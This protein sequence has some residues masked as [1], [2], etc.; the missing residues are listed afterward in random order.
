MNKVTIAWVILLTFQIAQAAVEPYVG[1]KPA[2]PAYQS[3]LRGNDAI[4]AVGGEHPDIAGRAFLVWFK[5]RYEPGDDV[6]LTVKD[7][8]GRERKVTY[9]TRAFEE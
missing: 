6:T 9:R 1:P 5:M 2:G 4:T 7:A 3:G 8:E